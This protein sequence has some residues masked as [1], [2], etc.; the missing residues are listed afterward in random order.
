[1]KKFINKLIF[2]I[3]GIICSFYI[4]FVA[5]TSRV[6]IFGAEIRD[7]LKKEGKNYILAF[8]HN[9]QFFLGYPEKYNNVSVLVSQSDDGEY[10]SMSVNFLGIKTIRGSS[11]R[12]GARALVEMLRTL[13][14]GKVVAITPD[15]PRGP[16]YEVQP[17]IVHLAKKTG[18]PVV[19]LSYSSKRKKIFSSWD[20]YQ[21]PYPFND[22]AVTY[23]EPVYVLWDES[24]EY[25]AEKIKKAIDLNTARAESLL[26]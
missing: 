8:W 3:T 18:F 1:M 7:K 17:G 25:A 4:F 16:L 11:T 15:G 2:Y 5:F 9:R 20:L 12:G 19:P 13:K 14:S 24:D 21:I 22:I 23:G 26:G 10:I 6:R